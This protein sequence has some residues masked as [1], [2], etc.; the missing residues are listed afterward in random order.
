MSSFI[1]FRG[2][3]LNPLFYVTDA[4]I[5]GGTDELHKDDSG[6]HITIS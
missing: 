2:K 5:D 6:F 4:Q 1:K 3:A